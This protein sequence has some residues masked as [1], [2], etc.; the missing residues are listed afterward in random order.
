MTST[1]RLPLVATLL[2]GLAAFSLVATSSCSS[3][4]SDGG[5]GGSSAG[6]GTGGGAGDGSAGQA[7]AAGTGGTAGTGGAPT[8]CAPNETEKCDCTSA[9]D[10]GTRRCAPDG[11][12]W[13]ACECASYGAEI[14]VSPGG[15]DSA[16][17][18]LAA[19][20]KTLDRA[21]QKVGELVSAGLPAGGVVVWL[22]DGTYELSATLTLGAAE[23]GSDGKPVVWRGYPGE[24]PRVVGGVRIDT[25]AFTPI[26]A[27][28]PIY[29]R[30][31]PPAQAAVLQVPLPVDPGAL[32][33]RG[34]CGAASKGPAELFV[35]GQAM[36]L[37]RWPDKD[38]NDV[39]AGLET[40][41][42]LD[43]YGSP[44]PDVSGHY[45]KT[46]TSDGVSAFARDGLVGGLQY[47]LYRYT[48]DYQGST[49]TAWFLTTGASGYPNDTNP[50]WYLYSSELGPMKPSAGGSGD[51]T[52]QNPDAINHGFASI[53]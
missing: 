15:D 27:S 3:D 4:S 34:F 53:A 9:T 17:G 22:R 10:V 2:F 41:N 48:W 14:A 23:S 28:S 21:R 7:G 31:D 11:S 40:A 47:N 18:T 26:S 1:K 42:A 32:V 16:A 39:A 37:S 50:W 49:N 19:P 51:V 5:S 46:G 36:T 38:Q 33:R 45:T 20:F 52:T 12:G 44:S 8:A 24:S 6:G 13:S 25:G 35:N 43:L 30:L 29:A